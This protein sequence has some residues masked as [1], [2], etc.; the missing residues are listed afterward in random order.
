MAARLGVLEV[1]TKAA[2]LRNK[3]TQN[4]LNIAMCN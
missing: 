1:R 3:H 4:S 2:K